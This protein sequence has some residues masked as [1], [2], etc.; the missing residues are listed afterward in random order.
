MENDGKETPLKRI[1]D[2]HGG[3]EQQEDENGEETP[4]KKIIDEHGERQDDESMHAT[5]S[6]KKTSKICEDNTP[7]QSLLED[8]IIYS[9]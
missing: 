1:I 7:S 9:Q 6:I 4:L 2:E 3:Q 5:K 8:P